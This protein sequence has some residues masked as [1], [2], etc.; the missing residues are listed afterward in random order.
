MDIYSGADT[1]ILILYRTYYKE[2]QEEMNKQL[3]SRGYELIK[4]SQ[5]DFIYK[6]ENYTITNKISEKAV[7]GGKP[8]TAYEFELGR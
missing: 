5:N 4:R 7:P 3:L 2:D 1:S 8:V 6:K